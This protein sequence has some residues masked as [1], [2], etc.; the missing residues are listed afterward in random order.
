[1]MLRKMN[2]ALCGACLLANGVFAQT[3][4]PAIGLWKTIDDNTNQEKSYVRIVEA[5]GVLSG[6]IEKILDV[7]QQDSTCE[8]CSD[9]RK[10]QKV[11]GMTI[12]DRLAPSTAE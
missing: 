9:G 1:M 8:K 11:L 2:V 5:S 7:N 6:R 12:I 10:N 4:D 3:T